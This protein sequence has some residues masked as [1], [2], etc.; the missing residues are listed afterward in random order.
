[1]NRDKVVLSSSEF[2]STSHIQAL[3]LWKCP[4]GPTTSESFLPQ[5]FPLQNGVPVQPEGGAACVVSQRK[6]PEDGMRELIL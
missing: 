4:Q 3:H 6:M 2:F 5:Q 1:M